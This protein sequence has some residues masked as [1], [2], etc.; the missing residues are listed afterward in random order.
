MTTT[1]A[2]TQEYRCRAIRVRA[3]GTRVEG[4]PLSVRTAAR[5]LSGLDAAAMRAERADGIP[6]W[7]LSVASRRVGFE[8]LIGDRWIPFRE[9]AAK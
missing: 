5:T 4:T 6:Q 3:D 1:K 9:I 2:K 7:T 8:A